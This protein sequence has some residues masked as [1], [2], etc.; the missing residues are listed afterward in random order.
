MDDFSWIHWMSVILKIWLHNLPEW[1]NLQKRIIC[2]RPI[3][4]T[5][6]LLKILCELRYKPMMDF[7]MHVIPK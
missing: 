5:Y 7:G 1:L 3:V 4:F 6:Q 2:K